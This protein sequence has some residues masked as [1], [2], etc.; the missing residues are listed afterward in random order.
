MSQKAHKPDSD[1]RNFIV[2]EGGP[3]VFG[4]GL[5]REG[6]VVSTT[7]L[8]AKKFAFL[9]PSKPPLSKPSS[10]KANSKS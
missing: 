5:V 3:H 6:D 4:K 7:E 2:G 1:L 9:S 10:Q 8:T